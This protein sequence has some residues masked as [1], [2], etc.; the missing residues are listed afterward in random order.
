M[1][2]N[3]KSLHV[4]RNAVILRNDQSSQTQVRCKVNYYWLVAPT[5]ANLLQIKTVLSSG[6]IFKV[7]HVAKA[8]QQVIPRL[9]DCFP[10]YIRLFSPH[11]FITK[12][13]TWPAKMVQSFLSLPY[14]L[15]YNQILHSVGARGGSDAESTLLADS[16]W[17]TVPS[18]HY[19]HLNVKTKNFIQ[20]AVL[21]KAHWNIWL[22]I[23]I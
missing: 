16:H 22:D 21:Y 10:P 23:R 15:S 8:E 4:R 5:N 14:N 20:T 2:T 7:K 17:Q 9:L 18:C 6:P 12:H 19:K 13:P 1:A 11:N 3:L